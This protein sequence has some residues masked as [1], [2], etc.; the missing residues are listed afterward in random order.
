MSGWD[1]IRGLLA[2]LCVSTTM[3]PMD[4][5][6]QTAED[7]GI[8]RAA[9][10]GGT[11]RWV[12]T[13]AD[14]ALVHAAPGAEASGTHPDGAILANMGCHQS[15]GHLWCDVR[16]FRGGPR[17]F[18]RADAL[19]PAKG[20][21]GTIAMGADDSRTRARKGKIDASGQIACAQEKGQSLGTCDAA[22]ARGTGGDATV[23]VTFPNQ[24][25]RMLYFIHG[26]FVRANATM[27]GVGR[28]KDW[29][30]KNGLHLIRV[31]D[32]QFEL[33]DSLVYGDRAE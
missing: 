24:F 23:V 27:S 12:V 15:E 10:E 17:G 26:E 25:K 5:A 21:D 32:Q 29:T 3:G 28:D 13:S 31:D 20:P 2:I 19:K 1:S 18:V 6:A 30:L 7:P 14:G 9:K 16:P 22:V 4:S 8:Y 33:S 11:R